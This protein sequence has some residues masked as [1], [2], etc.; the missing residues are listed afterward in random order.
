MSEIDPTAAGPQGSTTLLPLFP[1][2]KTVFFPHTD[3]PLFIFEPR[4]KAMIGHCIEQDA[5]FGVLHLRPRHPGEEER[6]AAA[7]VG[8]AG[9]VLQHRIVGKA[10]EMQ[11]LVRG[12]RRFRVLE[13]L[14][15]ESYLRGRVEWIEDRSPS[16]PDWELAGGRLR[17]DLGQ[18]LTHWATALGHLLKDDPEADPGILADKIIHRLPI[19]PRR[20]QEFLE[21]VD[22]L[23]RVASLSGLLRREGMRLGLLDALSTGDQDVFQRN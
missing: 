13:F 21:M 1:L 10:G 18:C 15:G 23:E 12:V 3:L 5:P 16:D 20:K 17:E 6:D 4:Y 7:R 22:P 2:S 19:D 9:K 8:G 11:I 14:S